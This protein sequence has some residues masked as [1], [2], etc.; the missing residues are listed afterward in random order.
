MFGSKEGKIT[1]IVEEVY[2]D[3]TQNVKP[4]LKTL[5]SRL[6]VEKGKHEV[7]EAQNALE[8]IEN[9]LNT[10]LILD[11]NLRKAIEETLEKELGK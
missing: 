4:V 11:E 9:R 3:L 10:L 1:K 2:V 8:R 6:G 5:I 7:V